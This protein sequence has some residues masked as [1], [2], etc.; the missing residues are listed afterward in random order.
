MS[1]NGKAY[2]AANTR[3]AHQEKEVADPKEA[4]QNLVGWIEG[5]KALTEAG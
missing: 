4:Q 1:S 3:A 5:L 2:G